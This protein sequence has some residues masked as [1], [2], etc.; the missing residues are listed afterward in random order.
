MVVRMVIVG[1][2]D[3]SHR[4]WGLGIGD[5]ELGTGDWGKQSCKSCK[6]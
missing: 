6:S 1:V 2:G 5:W 4:T 3:S